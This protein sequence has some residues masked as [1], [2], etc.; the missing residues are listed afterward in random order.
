MKAQ[1]CCMPMK[2]VQ[3]CFDNGGRAHYYERC[4]GVYAGGGVNTKH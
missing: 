1:L 4:R 3:C 2:V